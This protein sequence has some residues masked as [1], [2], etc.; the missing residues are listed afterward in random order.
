M[1]TVASRR[2]ESPALAWRG[3][4]WTYGDLL[5]AIGSVRA[6]IAARNLPQGAR[7]ALLLRN[8]P[9]YVALYYGALA[10][11]CVAVPLNAQERANVLARQIAHS[12][13]TL[14]VGDPAH[15]EWNAL[16]AAVAEASVATLEVEVH[17]G[18]DSLLRLI[19]AM[20]APGIEAPAANFAADHLAAIIYTSG[21][22]GRPK[23]VMLS[24]RNLHSNAEAII[25]YLG[26]TAADRGLC[27]LPFHFS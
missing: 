2:P 19:D 18:S 20:G 27:V 6:G 1:A 5:R 17:E 13:S 3:A 15:P 11:G 8:S 16:H 25:E 22:T 23:G 26:L 7:I 24:H 10:S 21:T 9:Q 14:L 4:Q 12:G